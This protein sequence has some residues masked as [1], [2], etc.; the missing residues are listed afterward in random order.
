VIGFW[1]IVVTYLLVRAFWLTLDQATRSLDSILAPGLLKIALWVM[2]CV[3]V[4]MAVNRLSP[5]AILREFGLDLRPG[6]GVAFGILAPLPL[7]AAVAFVGAQGPG[8]A[9]L[10]SVSILDPIAESVLFSA[11]LFSQLRRWNWRV[12]SAATASALLFGV[13]HLD[14][15][16]LRVAA[17]SFIPALI[18]A[19]AGGLL[20]TWLFHRWGSLWPAV[21]LH[22]AINFWWT[23]SAD[24]GLGFSQSIWRPLSAT[25]IAHGVSMAIAVVATLVL[26]RRQVSPSRPEGAYDLTRTV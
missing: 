14:G 19:S 17:M 3:A 7:A 10:I 2:P 15:F 21:A 9:E 20:F 4:T 18:G 25:A 6:G 8:I 22:A 12:G 11:F 5:R 13:A 26:T 16:E 23:L 24:L 1:P